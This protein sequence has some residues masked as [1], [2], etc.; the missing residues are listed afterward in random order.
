MKTVREIIKEHLEYCEY[1]G[2]YG[3]FCGCTVDN[4]MPCDGDVSG[5]TPGG[6]K[7]KRTVQTV[8][9]ANQKDMTLATA[10]LIK[11]QAIIKSK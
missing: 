5:C 7:V 11:T 2:L 10:L 8:Q 6:E 4:L 3:R 9:N 1:D